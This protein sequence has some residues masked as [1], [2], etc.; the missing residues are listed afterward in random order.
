MS[1]QP[2]ENLDDLF[3][4][5]QAP[6]PSGPDAAGA[7][8]PMPPIAAPESKS[9][10]VLVP[11]GIFGIVV[12]AGIVLLGPSRSHAPVIASIASAHL[13]AIGQNDYGRAYGYYSPRLQ[14][15]M[16]FSEFE[17]RCVGDPESW[18]I[19]EVEIK[20]VKIEGDSAAVALMA[21][22]KYREK[23][24]KY[25]IRVMLQREGSAWKIVG[26]VFQ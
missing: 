21:T 22:N 24:K 2:D 13:L 10:K 3:K 20:D 16:P 6:P 18:L 1:Q 4:Q 5:A 17:S 25:P 7:P 23:K 11:A 19:D 15:Q 14:K 26:T 8:A 9:L 12:L